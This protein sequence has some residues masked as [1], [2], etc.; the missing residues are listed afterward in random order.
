MDEKAQRRIDLPEGERR[1]RLV[2]GAESGEVEAREPLADDRLTRVEHH[3]PRSEWLA[4]V[5][6]DAAWADREAWRLEVV[7]L[8][9]LAE[10]EDTIETRVEELCPDDEALLLRVGRGRAGLVGP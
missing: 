6:H 10:M 7:A 3:I 8:D 1:A 5:E 4:V 9:L 2:L